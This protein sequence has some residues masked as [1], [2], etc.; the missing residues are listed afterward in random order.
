MTK[1]LITPYGNIT[2]DP[3]IIHMTGEKMIF[4]CSTGKDKLK[5]KKGMK[6]RKFGTVINLNDLEKDEKGITGGNSSGKNGTTLWI[7]YNHS[8][9]TWRSNSYLTFSSFSYSNR[10]P[11]WSSKTICRST[12]GKEEDAGHLRLSL[13][14]W[15]CVT[16]RWMARFFKRSITFLAAGWEER[17]LV[18]ISL[19][20][21]SKT[22]FLSF[23]TFKPPNRLYF[24]Y[25]DLLP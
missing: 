21:K 9:L 16:C 24:S 1:Q 11:E 10:H 13:S 7:A 18:N 20:L 3:R 6:N 8:D 4:T 25:S 14:P 2:T 12:D 5:D 15:P 22:L 23:F 17:I 19:S